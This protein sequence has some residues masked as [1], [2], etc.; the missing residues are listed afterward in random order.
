MVPL[1]HRF[2]RAARRARLPGLRRSLALGGLC[3]LAAASVAQGQT[4]L[5]QVAQVVQVS[6]VAQAPVTLTVSPGASATEI[7][8]DQV[9]PGTTMDQFLLALYRLNPQA[10][11]T[12]DIHRLLAHAALRLPTAEE[13]N[14]VP[15]EEARQTLGRLA[16]SASPGSSS[17]A[18]TFPEPAQP[19]GPK[20]GDAPAQ[21]P[22]PAMNEKAQP[23]AAAL[24]WLL[25]L[26]AVLGVSML[27]AGAAW[28][29]GRR[30][31][32]L[33]WKTNAMPPAPDLELQ[34]QGRF[35]PV[36]PQ[37]P[38]APG[39]SGPGSA[40][41]A[42]VARAG[43]APAA[44]ADPVPAAPFPAPRPAL[45]DLDLDLGGPAPALDLNIAAASPA[46][47][48]K[49]PRLFPDLNL[50][51]VP[52]QA[53]PPVRAAAPGPLDLS[54]ISLDLEPAPATAPPRKDA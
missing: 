54:G 46:G 1:M 17:S 22:P 47:A 29:R 24:P 41:L 8:L 39:A 28:L 33:K 21:T 27:L 37:E 20:R 4:P 19:E 51:P 10:F 3:A 36:L 26:G 23:S 31:Q 40:G 50:D 9:P 6:P 48:D 32:A 38:A 15:A 53:R 13:S 11:V 30:R 12:G 2:T 7:A 14:R 45:F 42:S 25:G 35:R 16:Q 34:A 52:S 18:Q 5:G 43:L 44:P 49:R